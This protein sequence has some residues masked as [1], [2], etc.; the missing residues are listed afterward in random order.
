MGKLIQMSSGAPDIADGN[1]IV[2][3][4]NLT[5]PREATM[6]DGEVV[7]FLDWT[8]ATESGVEITDSSTIKTG[9]KSK[10]RQWISAL[11]GRVLTNKDAFDPADLIG[12]M[13]VVTISNETGWP[14]ISNAGVLMQPQAVVQAPAAP[15]PIAAAPQIQ[16]PVELPL[17]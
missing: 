13:C 6:P 9:P 12:R 16:A 15:Q 3:L 8:F 7:N 1:Y 17:G 14:R 10:S 11:I 5:G 4:T 2:T